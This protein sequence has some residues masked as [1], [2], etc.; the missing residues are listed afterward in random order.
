LTRDFVGSFW[1]GYDRPAPMPGVHGGG[2]PAKA[3]AA[4]TNYYYLKLA[5]A[6][7]IA[8]REPKSK[9]RELRRIVP[10]E[11]L[12]SA[13][14]FGT[15]LVMCLLLARSRETSAAPLPTKQSSPLLGEANTYLEPST[16]LGGDPAEFRRQ[17]CRLNEQ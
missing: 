6:A 14:V 17:L 3:F 12:R 1:L 11:P 8:K 9:W 16:Q 15:M 13:L 7:V 2:G 10:D 5:H 4:M